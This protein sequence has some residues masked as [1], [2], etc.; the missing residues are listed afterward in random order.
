M[1]KFLIPKRR[2]NFTDTEVAM[3][4]LN[5]ILIRNCVLMAETACNET[6]LRIGC[7]YD[8]HVSPRPMPEL[9]FTDRN[10]GHEKFSGTKM[11]L[12]NWNDYMSDLVCRCA[13]NARLMSYVMF[14]LQFYGWYI[15]DISNLNVFCT[16]GQHKKHILEM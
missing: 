3:L 7:F 2:K 9:I 1:P 15:Y 11:D 6:F 10:T 8:H 4:I 16:A 12:I 13:R 5:T 14:S